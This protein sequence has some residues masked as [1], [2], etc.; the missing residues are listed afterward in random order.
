M[1]GKYFFT[2]HHSFLQFSAL[3]PSVLIKHYYFFIPSFFLIP[4]CI[5]SCYFSYPSPSPLF[6]LF[7]TLSFFPPPLTFLLTHTFLSPYLPPCLICYPLY[8][9]FFISSPLPF[10]PSPLPSASGNSNFGRINGSWCRYGRV[11][12]D[13]MWRTGRTT[14]ANIDIY[15][16]WSCTCCRCC[17]GERSIV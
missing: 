10:L 14:F 3:T 8:P 6:Y 11:R 1:P 13:R 2:P 7:S 12:T 16:N 9:N 15:G 5:S 17:K 4:V